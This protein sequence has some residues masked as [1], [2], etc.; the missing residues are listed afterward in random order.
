MMKNIEGIH[1]GLLRKVTG[2]K[3]QRLGYGTWQKEGADSVLQ[4]VG[5]KPLM[6]YIN[7]MRVK[8]EMW[9]VLWTILEVC[10]KETGYE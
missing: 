9:V 1:M 7:K 2:K 8:V 6:D 4:A 5:T 10:K 3:S